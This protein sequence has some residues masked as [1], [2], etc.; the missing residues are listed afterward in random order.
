MSDLLPKIYVACLASYNCGHLHGVW[1]DANQDVDV[2]Q[3]SIS[4]MLQLSPEPNA[5]SYEIHDS[6]DFGSLEVTKLTSL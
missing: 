2:L 4:A 6:E 1:L 3:E 5:E